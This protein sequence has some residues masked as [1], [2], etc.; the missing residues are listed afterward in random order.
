[1]ALLVAGLLSWLSIA[2]TTVN[3]ADTSAAVD[4]LQRSWQLDN[5]KVVAEHG[6]GR[7][8]NIY[9]YKCWMCHNQYTK[10]APLLKDLYSRKTLIG[11]A[12]V[13]DET[14]AAKIKDGGAAM[15]AFK[16]SLSDSDVADLAAYFH[17]GKCCVEGENP[18]ANPYYK[19]ETN[20]WPVQSGLNGGAAGMV[21][22]KSGDSPEGVGVQM[23]SPNGTR[24][25]VYTDATGKYEFPRMQ[26]GS[27]ILRIATPVP[28]KPYRKDGVSIDGATKLEDIVLERVSQ[29]DSLPASPELESQLSG[30]EIMFNLPGSAEEKAML[31]KNCSG[32]HSWQ[33]IFRSRYDE[34]GWRLIVDRMM[35]F[36]GTAIA[37]R[38]RPMNAPDPEYDTLVKFLTRVRSP[39]SPADAPL[40]VF[41]RPRGEATRVV[42]TEF[43]MPQQLLA[44]HDAAL[45][46]EGNVWFTS[47]KTRYVG[48]MDPKTGIFKE[49]TLPLTPGSMPGTHHQMVDKN[50]I[51]W[52]SE[53]WAHQLNR[54]DPKTGEVHQ[55][56]VA[57][58]TPINAPSFGNFTIDRDGFVWDGRAGRIV[59]MDPM[60]AE[61]LKEWP[62]QA[63]STYDN[64]VSYDGKYWGGSGPAN[65]GNTVE[66]LEIET[67]KIINLNSGEHMMTAKRGGFDPFGNTW[68]GGADG[69]LIE[70]KGGADPRIV[71][72]YPPIA[73]HPYTD[74]YEAMPDKNGEVWAGVLHGRQMLRFD[75]KIGKWTV[76]QMPEPYSYNR[77]T[78]IDTSTGK[79]T[80]WYVDYNNYLVRVQPLD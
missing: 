73:P 17:S 31:Q 69:A 64:T 13:N 57:S 5:Y 43:E 72:N 62:L 40:R 80:V 52:I 59:K 36:T 77:R 54:L 21:K 41:P 53:N 4:T 26:A 42:V 79:P 67:G 14:V 8:E 45:D 55:A 16:F 38:N 44:L 58:K 70:M 11:G 65:W 39:E 24:T 61:V 63:N 19:A 22:I 18:P 68:W 49:Y 37:V 46:N 20:K 74:F 23:I 56:L 7:G 25:T 34:K 60:T 28:F 76:Y 32:C 48:K 6:A 29:S 75:P 30:A 71:E 47:H 10:S 50:G 78:V 3:A 35:H 9:F 66:M 12:P 33:Q 51:V 27:Y 2:P 1:M 15:P